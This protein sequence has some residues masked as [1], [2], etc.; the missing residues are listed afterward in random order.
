MDMV[1]LITRG[2]RMHAS[3]REAVALVIAS[4]IGCHGA[5]ILRR[6]AEASMAEGRDLPAFAIMRAGA[7]GVRTAHDGK[8]VHVVYQ[9]DEPFPGRKTIEFIKVELARRGWVPRAKDFA[10]QQPSGEWL[11]FEGG[12][13]GPALS[14]WTN[15]WQDR[16]GNVLAYG[17]TYRDDREDPSKHGETLEVMASHYPR[18]EAQ[19]AEASFRTQLEDL[20]KKWGL[21]SVH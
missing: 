10:G 21:P 8:V 13:V 15:Y 16:K 20:V 6:G 1:R 11:P 5:G 4:L 18:S 17:L 19:R 3:R 12:S 14:L 9:I 2:M 7:Y